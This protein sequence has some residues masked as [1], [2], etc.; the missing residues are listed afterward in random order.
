VQKFESIQNTVYQK[1]LK[2]VCTTLVSL[3]TMFMDKGSH[4]HKKCIKL[5]RGI[6]LAR[7]LSPVS[8]TPAQ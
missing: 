3:Y 7:I 2:S 5:S 8:K 6:K 1:H 4:L